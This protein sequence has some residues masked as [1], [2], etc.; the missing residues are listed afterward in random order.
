MK[1][2]GLKIAARAVRAIPDGGVP[3][4]AAGAAR[5][6]VFRLL[7]PR[8]PLFPSEGR[9][10]ARFEPRIS[11]FDEGPRA[12]VAVPRDPTPDDPICAARLTRRMLAMQHALVNITRQARRLA[13]HEARRELAFKAG[14]WLLGPLRPGRPPG[15]RAR[16]GHPI[17]EIL[18]D[19][20]IFARRALEPPDTS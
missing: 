19:C 20:D 16:G 1:A 5:P 15:F 10:S 13:R 9:K 2:R 17:D 7:D 12:P 14:K 11:F 3:K 4:G 8:K 6:P 18:R